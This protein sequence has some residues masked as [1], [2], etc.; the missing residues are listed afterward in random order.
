MLATHLFQALLAVL[1]FFI[2][3]WIGRHSISS[4]YLQL[5]LF[6]RTDEAPAFNFVFRVLA[7]NVFVVL[8]AAISYSAGVGELVDRSYLIV[9]YYVGFRLAFNV[10]IGRAALLNWASQALVAAATVALAMFLDSRLV[11]NPAALLPDFSTI[12]NE[13]WLLI[14]VFLY[15]L[16]NRITLPTEGTERRKA[17]YLD[18]Q[19]ASYTRLYGD[20]VSKAASGNVVVELLAYSVLVYEGFHRPRIYQFI[21]RHIVLRLKSPT[22]IGPMQVQSSAPISDSESVSLGTKKLL[23]DWMS[24][25]Q[26]SNGYYNPIGLRCFDTL[27]KYNVRSD[28][29]SEVMRIYAVLAEKEPF[30]SRLAPVKAEDHAAMMADWGSREAEAGV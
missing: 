23:A 4:G 21:E 2:V 7:P 12:A 14:L 26:N 9:V 13:L 20:E 27:A 17:R 10:V 3:N 30:R 22:S 24:C 1:L 15:Q 28:Y 11:S 29:S 25:A 5:S 18:A 6:S 8:V 19:F 16:S